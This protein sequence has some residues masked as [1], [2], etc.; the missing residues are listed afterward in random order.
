MSKGT[1]QGG[2]TSHYVFM[3]CYTFPV[4]K[5]GRPLIEPPDEDEAQD[6]PLPS[7]HDQVEGTPT[8]STEDEEPSLQP[9]TEGKKH[10]EET[11]TTEDEAPALLPSPM[12]DILG[13]QSES[14]PMSAGE[15]RH[16]LA[17]VSAKETWEKLVTESTDVA[18]LNLSF[19]DI[20]PTRN[21]SHVLPALAR[22]HARL[23]QLGLP[24]MRIH[25]DRAKELTSRTVQ[26]WA[27]DRGIVVTATAGDS[28]K[29]IGRC[30]GELGIIKRL[31]RTMISSGACTLEQWPLAAR[32][33]GERRLRAQLSRMG[34]PAGKLLKFGLEAFAL[35]KWRQDR[36]APWRD[37]REP[38]KVLGPAMNSSI[39]SPAYYVQSQTT[40]RY[41]YTDDVVVANSEQPEDGQPSEDDIYLQE[42]GEHP[43]SPAWQDQPPTR[44][45]SGKQSPPQIATCSMRDI[46]GEELMS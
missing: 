45:I 44:R 24:V 4:D 25:S 7:S 10:G 31:T 17:A 9:P 2:L 14:E 46:E 40:G 13:E 27:A 20:V 19:V 42:Q 21:L 39:T 16:H 34:W 22:V 33:A 18:V 29:S 1:D 12:E 6:H 35:K 15:Q 36:Y 8:T 3:A 37:I 41:F 38:V 30:E 28:W 23:R 32:H 26:R 43:P 11:N 5:Q